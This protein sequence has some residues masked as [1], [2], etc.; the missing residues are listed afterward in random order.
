[1][2]ARAMYEKD[3]R[4]LIHTHMLACVHAYECVCDT[5]GAAHVHSDRGH[6]VAPV[7][8]II[9]Q[10]NR[11][12]FVQLPLIPELLRHFWRICIKP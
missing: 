6:Y 12:T 4:F 3:T 9:Q 7:G 11:G 8:T 2:C 5:R 1:M 10:K